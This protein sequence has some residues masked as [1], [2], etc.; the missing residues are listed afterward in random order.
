MTLTNDRPVLSSERAPHV[1]R[2][3]RAVTVKQELIF[4]GTDRYRLT[5]RPSVAMWSWLLIPTELSPLPFAV[6]FIIISGV[7]LSPLGTAATSGLLYKPQMIDEDDFWS[8]WWNEDWQGKPN[9]SEKTCRSATLPAWRN[10][11]YKPRSWL[12]YR[13]RNQSHEG[14]HSPCRWYWNL[15]LQ[16][17]GKFYISAILRLR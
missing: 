12:G 6:F 17:I 9:Y 1:D 10:T 4:G 8:Y 13:R 3:D 2:T 15:R 14:Q 7:G 5:D 16:P 11:Q